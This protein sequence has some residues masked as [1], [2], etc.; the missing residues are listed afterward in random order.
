MARK[1]DPRRFVGN[2]ADW[3]VTPAP[4]KE[5]VVLPS[6]EHDEAT[7]IIQHVVIGTPLGPLTR[8][9]EIFLE[10]VTK[11]IRQI[12]ADGFMPDLTYE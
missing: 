5:D 7:R 12:V 10:Q 9:G 8:A 11:E 2:P 6:V 3:V 1:S 4:P